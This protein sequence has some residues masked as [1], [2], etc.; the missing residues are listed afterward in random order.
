M[1]FEELV[2]KIYPK[3]SGII[4]N[5]WTKTSVFDREDMFS[6]ALVF[7]WSQWNG[8]KIQNKTDSF[9][10]QGCYFHLKNSARKTFSSS[11][12]R[13]LSLDAELDGGGV[14][15]EIIEEKPFSYD[16][17][18]HVGYIHMQDML[19]EREKRIVNYSLSGMTTREIGKLLGISH[20]MVVKITDKIRTKC[21]K[22]FK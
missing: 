19:N 6:E 4:A 10:L 9:V 21:C 2:K 22:I 1:N 8:G 20:V 3:L 7:L 12:T 17:L 13:W 5:M 18:D 16:T 14:L 15:E 11:E